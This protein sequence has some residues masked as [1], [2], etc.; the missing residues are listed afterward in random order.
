MVSCDAMVQY[1]FFD[2]E[3]EKWAQQRW[4]DYPLFWYSI[5]QILVDARLD[6]IRVDCVLD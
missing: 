3:F 2:L 6:I 4:T 5:Q 1:L